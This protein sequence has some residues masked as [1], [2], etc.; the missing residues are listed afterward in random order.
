MAT[1]SVNYGGKTLEKGNNNA[2]DIIQI[3]DWEY[4]KGILD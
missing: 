3:T 1:N 4:W 2:P